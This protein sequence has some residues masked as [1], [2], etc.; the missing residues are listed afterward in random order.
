MQRT[1]IRVALALGILTTAC[2]GPGKPAA[3]APGPATPAPTTTQLANPA[4]T[5]CVEIGGTLEIRD[6][7]GGQ[8]GYCTKGEQTCEEWALYRGE[9]PELAPGQPPPAE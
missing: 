6:E 4:S 5:Y 3:P 1:A 2:G 9:C 8:A 7:A